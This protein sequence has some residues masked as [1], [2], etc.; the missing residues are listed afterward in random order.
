MS[1]KRQRTRNEKI[2]R[3]SE[4]QHLGRQITNNKMRW[5]GHI[6]RMNGERILKEGFK[7]EC[8]RKI[9][10]SSQDQIGTTG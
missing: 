5:Y 7:H 6:L 2:Q 9:T 3:E 4:A 1:T 8:E 10:K